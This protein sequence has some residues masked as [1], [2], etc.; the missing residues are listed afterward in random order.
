M[1]SHF[2]VSLCLLFVLCGHEKVT[3]LFI[4]DLQHAEGH[5]KD[6]GS[7][8]LISPKHLGHHYSSVWDKYAN[9]SANLK[10]ELDN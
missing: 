2:Q 1:Q 3:H 4:V 8:G 7:K 5:L 10:N 9:E 6:M